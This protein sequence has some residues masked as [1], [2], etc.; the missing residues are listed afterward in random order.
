MANSCETFLKAEGNSHHL[1]A[2]LFHIENWMIF[3]PT[4]ESD[5]FR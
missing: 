1:Q 5:D 3:H 4:T 2:L